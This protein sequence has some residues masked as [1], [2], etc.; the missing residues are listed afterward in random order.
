MLNLFKSF[1]IEP[2]NVVNHNSTDES[3]FN[4][5]RPDKT[6]DGE[7]D[8]MASISTNESFDNLID[9]IKNHNIRKCLSLL[10]DKID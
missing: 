10:A 4:S 8:L 2:T 3:S 1:T 5:Y 9:N 6:I 7:N